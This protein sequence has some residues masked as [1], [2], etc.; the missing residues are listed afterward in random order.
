[1]EINFLSGSL[2]DQHLLS[3]YILSPSALGVTGPSD[4]I[5]SNLSSACVETQNVGKVNLKENSMIQV[6]AR[7][8]LLSMAQ[9]ST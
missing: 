3:K 2:Y 8:V 5:L 1:M 9:Q 4:Q 7:K 6:S